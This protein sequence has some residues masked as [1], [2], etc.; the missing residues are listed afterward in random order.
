MTGVRSMGWR[1]GRWESSAQSRDHNMAG[2]IG[3][4][5][6][7]H[8]FQESLSPPSTSTLEPLC[9]CQDLPVP[10]LL[11]KYLSMDSVRRLGVFPTLYPGQELGEPGLDPFIGP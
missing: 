6:L 8:Q 9:P 11:V 4:G 2:S 5:D 10:G 1:R 3:D 7:R